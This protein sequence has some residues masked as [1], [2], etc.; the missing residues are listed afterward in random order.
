MTGLEYKTLHASE[1]FGGHGAF[2]IK[3]MVAATKL[4]NLDTE[5]IWSA[6]YKAAGL[7]TAEVRAAAM[8][9]DEEAQ[10]HAKRQR[11]ELL[12]LFP[13]RIFVE[14]IPNGYCSDWCCRHLPWF[15]VTTEIGR[16]K[17]G[18]RKRV[19][20]LEWADTVVSKSAEE[21]FPGEDVTKFERTI[22]AWGLDKARQYIEA[23]IA[24]AEC[25]NLNI[26][27]KSDV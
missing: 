20:H 2:G 24:A 10:R 15:I 7:V 5:A 19:I 16:F 4:P 14:A 13:G 27:R 26:G 22:H 18:W 9:D 23:V 17:I 21:L 25:S 1:S 3:I 8:A 6:A 12:D 11:S